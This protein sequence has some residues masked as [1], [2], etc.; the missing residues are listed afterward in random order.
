MPL[1]DFEPDF[2]GAS[3]YARLYRS[4]DIQVVPA[5]T[6]DK[7]KAWKLPAVSW[8]S[9]QNELVPELTFERWYGPQGEHIRRQNMGII[10]GK[11]S[12]N[13]FVVDVDLHRNTDAS[14]WWQYIIE[15]APNLVDVE[16]VSQTTGGGG[17]QYL[18][19]APDNWTAPTFK[20][21]IG[22]DIR[23]QGGFA[24]M[25][26]SMHE[27]GRSYKWDD[28]FEP[29]SIEIAKAPMWLCREIDKLAEKHGGR[30]ITQDGVIKTASPDYATNA[31]GAIV[32]GR[33]DYM[34]RMIWARVVDLR[35]DAP[36]V[37]ASFLEAEM[38]ELYIQ[39]SRLVKSRITEIGTSN[40]DLLEREGRGITLFRQKWK[41]A[42]DQ[43][44]DKVTE[45]AK[46]EK[47]TQELP[48]PEAAPAPAVEYKF[49][50]ETGEITVEPLPDGL[51]EFLDIQQ[52]KTMPDPKFIVAGIIAENSFGITG[53][54][55]G[56]GK[57][58]IDLGLA[59]SIATNQ[60]EWF[61]RLI[62][63][64]GPV[65]Y[66]TNEG[67]A[68]MKYRIMAW[69]QHHSV[70]A[71]LSPFFLIRQSIN[72]MAPSDIMKLLKTV[73]HIAK[74]HSAP[75][76]VFVDTVSRVLPGADENLQKDMTV[77]IAA[78]DAV[79]QA[80]GSAVIGVHHTSRQGN[81]RGSTVF[82]GAADFILMVER[83]SG[84]AFGTMT[85][86]KIKYAQDGWADSFEMKTVATGSITGQESL[87]AVLA[88]QRPKEKVI[89]PDLA[90]LEKVLN[91][92]QQAF[93]DGKAWAMSKNAHHQAIRHVVGITNCSPKIA[94]DILE[95]WQTNRVIEIDCC[96]KK[97]KKYGFKVIGS[98]RS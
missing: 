24:V 56:S 45:H 19:R 23:G 96:D 59:L 14:S 11:A 89:W 49:D 65:I 79:R 83:E 32:D 42:T 78:C 40:D 17:K 47:V 71:T 30:T 2:A 37:S 86:T 3:D 34:T 88:E 92:M 4:L 41:I 76:A 57:S 48:R 31:F 12:N 18:F 50:A 77:F 54:A 46:V 90:M 67:L 53:G 82:E 5:L 64:H 27:S 69:E 43:W 1:T 44:W 7:G 63:K 21:S 25:P 26:P 74:E 91:E 13:I 60:K 68:D 94:K 95:L 97:A 10:T 51:Y 55:P 73:A 75:V 72:F 20:T 8:K 84:A 58:F 35:R 29:W 87:V 70:Q 38:N 85:A 36:I 16:T 15:Q 6:P 39:Y 62:H 81:L 98:I 66:I 9:L 80:F 28:G 33:E 52:I 22:V 61:G 93:D